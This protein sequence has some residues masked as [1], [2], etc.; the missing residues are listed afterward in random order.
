MKILFFKTAIK[1]V[2]EN[3]Y[4]DF[5]EPGD[6]KS[7]EHLINAHINKKRITY[8]VWA[9][10]SFLACPEFI[11]G[12]FSLQVLG[13]SPLR[14]Y[15]LWAFRYNPSRKQQRASALHLD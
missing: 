9:C 13:S 11:S 12:G 5:L 14:C 2:K 8:C 3:W 15:G 4:I 1:S 7:I 10:P 6:G